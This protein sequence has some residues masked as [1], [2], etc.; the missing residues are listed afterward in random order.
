VAGG[1]PIRPEHCARAN[2]FDLSG[3]AKRFQ[4]GAKKRGESKENLAERRPTWLA[5]SDDTPLLYPLANRAN[6]DAALKAI[7]AQ[8]GPEDL[9]FVFM[10]SHGSKDLF[11]LSFPEAGTK[12]LTASEFAGMLDQS[13]IGAA[14]IVLSACY[15]GSLIDNIAAPDRLIIAAAR[16]DRTSFGCADGADWTE[17]G[18]SY[19]DLALR[20]EPDP[21]RAFALAAKD[22]R[23]KEFWSLRRASLPQIDEGAAIG[24]VLDRLLQSLPVRASAAPP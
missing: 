6:L 23:S 24:P 18:R 19:F 4:P 17:F 12:D 5:N 15:S 2:S 8:K 10:T 1:H 20:A 11:S 13:G 16:A 3:F 22:V 14:V 21:R 9:A 7:A